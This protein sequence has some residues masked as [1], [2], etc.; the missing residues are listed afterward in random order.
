MADEGAPVEALEG[1]AGSHHPHKK[2][3]LHS[4][5]ERHQGLSLS[6]F[7]LPAMPIPVSVSEEI[8]TSWVQTTAS[9]LCSGPVRGL[10]IV[11][12]KLLHFSLECLHQDPRAML[13][14]PLPG[15]EGASG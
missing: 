15:Q 6:L 9:S 7:S 13:P 3:D 10:S 2:E 5:P 1:L 8:S 14:T 12:K 11:E 4:I